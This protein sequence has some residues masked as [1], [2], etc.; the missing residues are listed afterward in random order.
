MKATQVSLPA[1]RSDSVF[2]DA[3]P[4]PPLYLPLAKGETKRGSND[5]ASI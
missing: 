2:E 5:D 1:K 4:E 3:S